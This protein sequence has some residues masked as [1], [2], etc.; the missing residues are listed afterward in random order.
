MKRYSAEEK[1]MWVE[2]WKESG[3]GGRAY[4][5]ANGLNPVTFKKWTEEA[6][7]EQDFVEIPREMPE[8]EGK[9]PEILIEKGDVRIHIPLGITRNEL[10]GVMEGLGCAV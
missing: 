4:A 8:A 5:K 7:G 2:D 6:M 3:I 1:R 10:R 9:A